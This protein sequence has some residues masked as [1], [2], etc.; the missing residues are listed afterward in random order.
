MTYQEAIKILEHLRDDVVCSG[1]YVVCFNM[2][3]SAMEKQVP[4]LPQFSSDGYDPEGME[5]WDAHCPN[6][7]HELDGD[8]DEDICPNCG[9]AIDWSGEE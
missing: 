1:D 4:K 5:V 2:A 3:I 9:Q 7:E 6:C 8:G